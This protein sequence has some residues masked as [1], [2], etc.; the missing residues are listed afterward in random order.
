MTH[1]T[2]TLDTA[3]PAPLTPSGRPA[4]HPYAPPA[5]SALGSISSATAGSDGAKTLDGLIGEDGGFVMRDD[6]TS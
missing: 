4:R 2:T 3:R 6:M 1:S 5:L